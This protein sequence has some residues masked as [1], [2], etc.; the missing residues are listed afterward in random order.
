MSK[1]SWEMVTAR[2]HNEVLAQRDELVA[3]LN[4]MLRPGGPLDSDRVAARAA[5][6]KVKA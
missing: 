6:A 2:E 5:L 3:A 4:L 1:K